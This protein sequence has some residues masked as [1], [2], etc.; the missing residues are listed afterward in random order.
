MVYL[1]KLTDAHLDVLRTV[2]NPLNYP[3]SPAEIVRL[4]DVIRQ[5]EDRVKLTGDEG[6]ALDRA[7]KRSKDPAIERI[8]KI[9]GQ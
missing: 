5:L 9:F 2:T 1:V 6:D 8:K 3:L 7:W 4:R